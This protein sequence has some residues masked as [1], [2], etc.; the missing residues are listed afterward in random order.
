[1]VRAAGL[2]SETCVP[3]NKGLVPNSC[4]NVPFLRVW[5]TLGRT[6]GEIIV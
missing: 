2:L 3:E 1:M 4:V 5:D 6:C